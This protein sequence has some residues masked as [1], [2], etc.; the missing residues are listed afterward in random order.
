MLYRF[1]HFVFAIFYRIVY[2]RRVYGREHIPEEGPLIICA[3]HINWQDPPAIGS[4]LPHRLRIHFMAK[5][6][7][8]RNPIIAYFLRKAGAFSVDR[9]SADYGAIRRAFQILN[10]GGVVGL[11]PEGTR[12]KTGALQKAQRGSALIAGRSGAPLLPVL[13]VGPYRPGRPLRIICGPLFKIPRLEYSS[14]NEK[15]A[16]LEEGSRMIMDRLQALLPADNKAQNDQAGLR[17]DFME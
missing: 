12:S 17:K 1:G 11:F 8:F 14:R 4:A 6:E 9:E 10:A 7:L 15:K 5:K 16:R 13:V 3:N 2:R